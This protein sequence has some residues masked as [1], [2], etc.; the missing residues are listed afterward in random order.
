MTI[1]TSSTQLSI[2]DALI[3]S[4]GDSPVNHSVRPDGERAKQMTATSGR[5][6]AE[7]LWKQGQSGSFL[8]TLLD[9]SPF[10]S[11]RVYL[12]WKSKRLSF[13]VRTVNRKKIKRSSA[14]NGESLE[15]LFQ[16]LAQQDMYYRN[17]KTAHK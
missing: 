17:L 15:V 10:W 11:R 8:K 2:E 1:Y 9:F 14:F 6:L 5:K 13:F 3:L 4:V 12:K 7:L 16:N